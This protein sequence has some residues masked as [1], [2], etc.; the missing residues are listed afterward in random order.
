MNSTHTHTHVE[1]ERIA[2][3]PKAAQSVDLIGLLS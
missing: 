3:I 2:A 1:R